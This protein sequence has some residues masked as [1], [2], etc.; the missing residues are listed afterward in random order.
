MKS[1]TS[2][3][4][5]FLATALLPLSGLLAAPQVV[6]LWPNGAPGAKG[7]EAKD[8]PI[9]EVYCPEANSSGAAVVVFPGG[10]YGSLALDHEGKQ[11]A[12]FYNSLGVTAFVLHYRLG[13][14]GYHHP[15]EL[16]DAKRSIRWVRDHAEEYNLDPNRIGINGFSA[17]GHLASTAATLF[18]KGD[19]NA[20]DPI[21]RV[22]SRPDFVVLCYPVISL[23]DA[24]THK[25]SR[26]NLL[27]PDKKDDEAL[28]KDLSSQL[29]VTAETPPT[30]I[31]QTDEDTVVPA[32]N[33]IAYYL[34][35]RKHQIPAEMHIYQSGPHGVGL[36]HG[37]PV[38]S[39]WSKHLADW[40][41]DNGWLRPSAKASVQ[42]TVSIN[43]KPVSWGSVTFYPE[44]R[45]LPVITARLRDGKFNT[46]KGNRVPVGKHR[47]RVLFSAEDVDKPNS[48][49]NQ[50]GVI[51]TGKS[52]PDS[53]DDITFEVKEGVNTLPLTLTW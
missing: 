45:L 21:E 5:V 6:P 22:S 41:R 25:G 43:D 42:G 29:N 20:E 46:G 27:G 26:A 3:L 19:P 32:E 51:E 4:S 40:L 7:K 35:L 2:L 31:F 37:D 48:D 24:S 53:T 11:I 36:M 47:I 8:I 49:E 18:D 28:A 1:P 23:S 44:D 12:Q 50:D 16:N 52:S 38:L 9:L 30:F 17:G 13:T 39:T 14:N 15:I 10:G 33:A 34:A